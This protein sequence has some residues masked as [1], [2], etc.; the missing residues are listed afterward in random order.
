M[1]KRG[2]SEAGMTAIVKTTFAYGLNGERDPYRDDV[3]KE[4]IGNVPMNLLDEFL[5]NRYPNAI[6]VKVFST[7]P[8]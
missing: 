2:Q 1:A 5:K 6:S 8:A 4:D 7:Q 3:L